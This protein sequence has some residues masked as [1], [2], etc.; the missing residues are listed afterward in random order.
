MRA[1]A[2]RRVPAARAAVVPTNLDD[3]RP[4][5]EAARD[6]VEPIAAE[7]HDSATLT[8]EGLE[9]VEAG[10]RPVFGVRSGHDNLVAVE[11]GPPLPL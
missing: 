11:K 7:V 10:P 2:I 8:E 4:V 6:P 3:R 9:D 5:T 1:L